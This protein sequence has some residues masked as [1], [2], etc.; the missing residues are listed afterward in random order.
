MQIAPRDDVITRGP[1][2]KQ[3]SHRSND[4]IH[5]LGVSYADVF[6]FYVFY[7]LAEPKAQKTG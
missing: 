4:N 2:Q 3:L 5:D 1:Q 6:Y 7:N